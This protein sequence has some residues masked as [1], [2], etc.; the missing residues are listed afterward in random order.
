MS[1]ALA[2]CHAIKVKHFTMRAMLSLLAALACLAPVSAQFQCLSGNCFNG[3]SEC[4]YPSGARFSGQ[5]VDGR[6]HGQGTIVFSNGDRYTGDWKDHHREGQGELFFA[7][8]RVYK[9]SFVRNTFHG[10]GILIYPNGDR[11][12][13][14][15][16]HGL[17]HGKGT[18]HQSGGSN[19]AGVWEQDQYKPEWGKSIALGDT[20]NLP[21]CQL[22][23][24][25]TGLGKFVYRDGIRYYGPFVKGVPEGAGMVYYPAGD[26][27]EGE[28]K[29]HAPN[30]H[31][32]MY[33]KTGRVLGA[34]W[35]GGKPVRELFFE[36]EHFDRGGIT[37]ERSKE[38]RIWAV[39]IGVAQYNH[40]PTLRY[41]DDDAYQLF[42][43]LKSPEGGALPDNQIRLLIDEDATKKN[44]L[45][46]MRA[47]LLRADDNDVVLFYF[48]GHGLQGCFLPVDYDGY[49][50]KLFHHEV[51]ELLQASR[52]KHKLV[53][54]DACHA[55]TLLAM[56]SGTVGTALQTYYDAFDKSE[57]GLALLLS[58]KGEEYSLE[59][60]GL[61]SGVFSHF[62][63]RGLK[64]EADKDKNKI[65]TIQELHDFVFVNV[66]RYTA[67]VQSPVLSGQ[68]DQN[69]PVGIVR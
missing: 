26:R 65:V 53:L 58:S 45:D 52:A 67:G 50:N 47:V 22:I 42:A 66:R 59:D 13:G 51:R 30:G 32:V 54:A 12:E 68:F 4:V 15:F 24:C 10:E 49:N 39:V 44:I 64:G 23:P 11:Y 16:A 43:F 63:I 5:F 55:G 48:S 9:G 34:V 37:V 60:G 14:Q 61:R 56:R 25:A 28:W 40:M 41:T 21:N 8:G 1:N 33:Y 36:S 38:V 69:M 31:G 3:Y 6:I 20:A 57:G 35:N 2:G 62:L 29:S 27:Y 19:L 46:A 18:L 7:D 17:R